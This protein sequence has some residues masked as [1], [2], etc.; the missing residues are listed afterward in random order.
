MPLGLPVSEECELP[1]SIDG[2]AIAQ[3]D[4]FI[5]EW[6]DLVV[7]GDATG[8]GPRVRVLTESLLADAGQRQRHEEG[9]R[10]LARTQRRLLKMENH[11]QT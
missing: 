7:E 5:S 10:A 11:T 3:M 1:L 8:L 9:E 4:Q 2:S 6:I